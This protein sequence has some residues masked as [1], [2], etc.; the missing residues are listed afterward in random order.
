MACWRRT[1]LP[2]RSRRHDSLHCFVLTTVALLL[3]VRYPQAVCER[4]AAGSGESI[5]VQ[6]LRA[7]PIAPSCAIRGVP[8]TWRFEPRF[9]IAKLSLSPSCLLGTSYRRLCSPC[10]Y[11]ALVRKST[12]K[13][14]AIPLRAIA[15]LSAETETPHTGARS[16]SSISEG[17]WKHGLTGWMLHSYIIYAHTHACQAGR[18]SC[19]AALSLPHTHSTPGTDP[20]AIAASLYLIDAML[21]GTFA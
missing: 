3:A 14:L 18:A 17:P 21:S 16:S 13:G 7:I 5:T 9:P 20:T 1:I 10:V 2:C 6:T 4:G 12:R 19:T 15:S 8:R 11:Q